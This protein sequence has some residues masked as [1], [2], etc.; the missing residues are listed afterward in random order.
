MSFK[1]TVR[2]GKQFI[3]LKNV[4]EYFG[5]FKTLSDSANLD[6]DSETFA[7]IVRLMI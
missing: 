2:D 6:C 3:I 4:F 5:L 1:I 7:L